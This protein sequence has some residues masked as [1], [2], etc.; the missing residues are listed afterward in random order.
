MRQ[1]FTHLALSGACAALVTIVAGTLAL[2]QVRL[3]DPRVID[4]DRVQTVLPPDAI[5]AIDDPAFVRAANA[6]FM[7]DEEPVVALVHRGIA[8]A[9]SV[10]HL[11]RHEIVNDQF[12]PDPLAVTW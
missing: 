2:A 10:W 4:G 8:K 9:Y 11:D 5:P 12:G 6:A 7:R 3:P 1:P